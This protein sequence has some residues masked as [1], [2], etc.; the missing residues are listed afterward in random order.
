[1]IVGMGGDADGEAGFGNT[2]G[3]MADRSMAVTQ[4]RMMTTMNE[5]APWAAT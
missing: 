3:L 4:K 5:L 2:R 1:M